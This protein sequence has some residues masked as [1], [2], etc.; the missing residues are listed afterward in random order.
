LLEQRSVVLDIGGLRHLHLRK[1]LVEGQ[2]ALRDAHLPAL[3]DGRETLAHVIEWRLPTFAIG[4]LVETLL[5]DERLQVRV[6]PVGGQQVESRRLLISRALLRRSLL[7]LAF[8]GP[9]PY[10]KC[11]C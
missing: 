4:T 11:G 10:P 3:V 6:R 2:L 9:N 8:S 7:L 5:L 1:H